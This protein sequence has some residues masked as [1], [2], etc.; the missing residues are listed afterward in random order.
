MNDF[1]LETKNLSLPVCSF[2]DL[3]WRGDLITATS[4]RDYQAVF[5]CV[6]HSFPSYHR[7]YL[8]TV[9]N[10]ARGVTEWKEETEES[11]KERERDRERDGKS[12]CGVRRAGSWQCVC[13]CICGRSTVMSRKEP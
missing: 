10:W 2:I 5:L 13:V 8:Q 4:E 7:A 12:S 9:K 1:R 3:I 6:C 11:G